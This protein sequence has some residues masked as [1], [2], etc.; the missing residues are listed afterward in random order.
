M[1]RMP[2]LDE[3]LMF[4]VVLPIALVV[5]VALCVSGWWYVEEWREGIWYGIGATIYLIWWAA[6]L[7]VWLRSDTP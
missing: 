2:N 4:I 1:K 7:A 6:V 3:M 5:V